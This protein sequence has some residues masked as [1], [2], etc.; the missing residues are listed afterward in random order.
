[1]EAEKTGA[2][3]YT[4]LLKQMQQIYLLILLIAYQ[5]LISFWICSLSNRKM[6]EHLFSEQ[7]GD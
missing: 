3:S 6:Q 4:F 2:L 1:M 7:T 5:F